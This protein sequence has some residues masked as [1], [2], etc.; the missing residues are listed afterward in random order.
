MPNPRVALPHCAQPTQHFQIVL[1][2]RAALPNCAQPTQHFQIVP[3]P[4]ITSKL[5]PA[6][7]KRARPNCAQRASCASTLCRTRAALVNSAQPARSGHAYKSCA[8]RLNFQIAPNP[9]AARPNCAQS[10]RNERFQLVPSPQEAGLPNCAQPA[11][12]ASK[13]CRTRKLHFQIV[14]SS[15]EAGAFKLCPA[16]VRS[17]RFQL[18]PNP[19]GTSKLCPTREL[20][21]QI[22]PNSRSTSKLC[23]AR[24]LHFAALPN[25][26]QPTQKC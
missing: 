6:R 17:R 1:N 12:C 16:R 10:A 24:V 7:E 13:L 18:V 14:P 2:L 11:S 21:F 4:R 8:A 15:R 9:R 5:C 22:V 23:P 26:A 19:R 20:H 25:C 3:H